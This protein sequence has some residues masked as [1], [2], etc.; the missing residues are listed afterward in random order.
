MSGFDEFVRALDYPVHVVTAAADGERDGCLVGFAGQCSIDPPR[1]TVWLSK[2]NRTYALAARSVVLAVHTL[3]KDQ[4]ELARLFGAF[5]A[6]EG[7]DK[8]AQARWTPGP[9]GVPLLDQA[10]A[11]FVGRILDRV[12]W[13]DHVGFL[14]EP[15]DVPAP[16]AA[17]PEPAGRILMFRQ[18]RDLDAGHP[19]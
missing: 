2:A 16:A 9:H 11:R 12:D 17:R 10:A 18:V 15:L 3:P 7:I 19:A 1:F 4:H 8:F 6:D 14:L 5:T 13:G